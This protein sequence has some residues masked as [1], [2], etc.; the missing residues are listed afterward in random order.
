MAVNGENG[1]KYR[2][3]GT[4]RGIECVKKSV[5][6]NMGKVVINLITASHFG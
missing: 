5:E 2:S 3:R 4:C 6:E 1:N